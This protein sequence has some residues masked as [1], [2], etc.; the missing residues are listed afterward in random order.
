MAFNIFRQTGFDYVRIQHKRAH[1]FTVGIDDRGGLAGCRQPD[2]VGFEL[3]ALENSA[4]FST[5][6]NNGVY[7][8]KTFSIGESD[9]K[10]YYLE[11]RRIT[12]K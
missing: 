9:D 8:R 10:R 7:V 4:F 2:T 6:E 1:G 3:P 11:A 12:E 5:I